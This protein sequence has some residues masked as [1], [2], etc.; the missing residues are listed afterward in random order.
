MVDAGR[1]AGTKK[2]AVRLAWLGLVGVYS[3]GSIRLDSQKN[4]AMNSMAPIALYTSCF[5]LICRPIDR[6]WLALFRHRFASVYV[7]GLAT[8]LDCSGH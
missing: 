7:D 8:V 4:D 6:P 3:D 1:I 5:S 2:P